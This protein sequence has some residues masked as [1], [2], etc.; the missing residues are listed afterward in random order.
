MEQALQGN[1]GRF[2]LPE[3]FQ[4]IAGSRKS[5]T[6]GIQKDDDIVMVYFKRGRIIYG[7]GPRKTYH[8]GQLLRDRGRITSEQLEEAVAAQAKSEP[9][10]RLGR[11]MIEKKY[12]HA[13]DLDKAVREQVEELVY[14]ILA[15]D[16]GTFKFYENQYPTDEEITVDISAENAI[17]EGY[18]RIDEMNRIKEALPDFGSVLAVVATPPERN[19]D[20]SLRSEEWNLLALINGQRSINEIV[21]ISV[22]S[23]METLHKL[24]AMK[25]AGLVSVVG[26]REA[27][28]NDR[29]EL[30]VERVARLLEE[31][32]EHKSKRTEEKTTVLDVGGR[33]GRRIAESNLVSKRPGD[34]N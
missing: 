22:L 24:A 31:Y 10:V 29:L 4:L 12:I 14:S 9:S 28:K 7:Y 18:R 17:L 11:I 26:K 5:G 16:S 27:E 13:G 21:D 2:T 15:W 6:L 34:D 23:E 1:I 33:A 32:L 19:T 30:M 8:L 3:I 25:L 20:I